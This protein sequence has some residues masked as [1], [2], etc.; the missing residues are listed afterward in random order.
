MAVFFVAVMLVNK[1]L[2]FEISR[3]KETETLFNK[4]IAFFG[5][6]AVFGVGVFFC[7]GLF[8]FE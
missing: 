2:R 5:K 3:A 7:I 6:E 1:F 8:H 4:S